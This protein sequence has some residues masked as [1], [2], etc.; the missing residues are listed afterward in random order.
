MKKIQHYLLFILGILLITNCTSKELLL[1][2]DYESSLYLH[3]S[4]KTAEVLKEF[5]KGE[6][7]A[8][9]TT[10][11]KTYLNLLQGNSDI[12]A[13]AKQAIFIEKRFRFQAS[14]E[15]KSVFF[16]ETAEGY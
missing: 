16:A 12:K 4:G 13:L 6:V 8:F 9:I 3:Q 15:L 7:G 14:K 10:L 2:E 11:E 5:P 1:K